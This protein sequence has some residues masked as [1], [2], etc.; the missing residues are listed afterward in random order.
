MS[1]V[2]KT[3]EDAS[4]QKMFISCQ[5]YDRLKKIESE[6]LNLKKNEQKTFEITEQSGTGKKIS[7]KVQKLFLEDS[8]DEDVFEKIANIVKDKIVNTSTDLWGSP[9]Q[10]PSTSIGVPNTLPPLPF[11]NSILKNDENDK[12]GKKLELN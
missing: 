12:F 10:I 6:Y 4:I 7:H 5:E 2:P 8:D 3:I 11:A 9:S 1:R